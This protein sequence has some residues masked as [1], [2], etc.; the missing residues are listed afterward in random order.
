M[1]L[2]SNQVKYGKPLINNDIFNRIINGL[3]IW[4]KKQSSSVIADYDMVQQT[5]K[6]TSILTDFSGNNNHAS[7]TGFS[8][9]SWLAGGGL[10]FD[11]S[12]TLISTPINQADIFNNPDG[13]S[14]E[15]VLDYGT[16]SNYRGVAGALATVEN[17]DLVFLQRSNS[18][19]VGFFS[20]GYST[21]SD[22]LIPNDY[23]YF[24]MTYDRTNIISYLNN[25]VNTTYN[26]PNINVR[27]DTICIGKCG[28]NP[29][30]YVRYMDG[31][32]K[33]FRIHNKALS[34][35]EILDNYNG[36]VSGGYL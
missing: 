5:N 3:R 30:T 27:D 28:A 22:T 11:G 17:N 35:Q 9:G 7:M 18:M 20:G 21:F 32:I 29:Q 8:S 19:Q 13:A 31:R 16:K 10:K 33:R 14:I 34:S 24:A 23:F 25:S 2:T 36:F 12:S 4:R 26:R 1:A 15:A 6:S